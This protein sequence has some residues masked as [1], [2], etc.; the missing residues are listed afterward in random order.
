VSTYIYI[1]QEI[2]ITS[3]LEAK[4][5]RNRNLISTR[6]T[7][8]VVRVLFDRTTL[9]SI[10]QYATYLCIEISVKNKIRNAEDIFR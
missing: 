5:D 7:A 8:S 10:V 4:E 3:R 6:D 1:Y 2:N 9:L